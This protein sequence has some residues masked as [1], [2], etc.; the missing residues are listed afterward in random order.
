MIHDKESSL[1][2]SNDM[3]ADAQDILIT[4][5]I[6]EDF[7]QNQFLN[8][9]LK[10]KSLW[11]LG[12]G[13]IMAGPFI[14][15]NWGVSEA[16]PLGI[17]IALI[18]LTFYY[19]V[20]SLI[21]SKLSV[22]Y[23][24]IGG[25]YGYVRQGLGSFGAYWA[26]VL[27]CF[28]FIGCT[29]A[30]LATFRNY[31]ALINLEYS[32]LFSLGVFIL[33]LVSLQLFSTRIMT[34]VHYCL[35]CCALGVLVIFLLGTF[36]TVQSSNLLA[37]APSSFSL[38]EILKALP[39]VSLFF[40]GLENTTMAAEEVRFPER[41]M[42][43]GLYAGFI[44]AVV[45]S[46]CICFFTLGSV[47]WQLLTG[48][49][50]PLLFTL[51][52]V[53]SQDK[54]LLSTF[55][56]MSSVGFIAALQGFISGYSRQVYALSRGGYFPSFLSKLHPTRKTY[57]F[58]IL[59]PGVISLGLSYLMSIKLLIVAAFYSA[60]FVHLLVLI[61]FIK[62]R[63]S[64]PEFFNLDRSVFNFFLLYMTIILL[65]GSLFG[66]V[67]N[68]L[69]DWKIIVLSLTITSLYYF[70]WGVRNIHQDAPEEAAAAL[71]MRRNRIRFLN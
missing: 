35:T 57:H 4:N 40:L 43:Y 30:V 3:I 47:D 52:Q 54:V 17:L 55:T 65:T 37:V 36:E 6:A 29:A 63:N 25:A 70:I 2:F 5:R 60:V 59:V 18:I 21:T 67:Q 38:Q 48:R 68:H 33:L 13:T 39:F 45:I 69:I 58:A 14:G 15:W 1:V 11:V 19:L 44:T 53:Q 50:F 23:P 12:A 62:I 26:G 16:G 27:T 7:L 28:Q 34:F 22:L 56:V 64:E 46:F 42:P 41:C 24:F 71:K 32:T 66:L 8:K 9:T 51:V 10:I 31:L 61:S 49:Q 20:F